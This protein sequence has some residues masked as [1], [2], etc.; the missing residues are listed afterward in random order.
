M[1]YMHIFAILNLLKQICNHPALVPKK[2]RP[3]TEYT[4]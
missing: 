4:G 3:L 1:P 2:T